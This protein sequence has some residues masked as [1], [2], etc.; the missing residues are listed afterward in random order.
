MS[1]YFLPFDHSTVSMAALIAPMAQIVMAGKGTSIIG[2][3]VVLRVVITRLSCQ[4][5]YIWGQLEVRSA[6]PL[7]R[8][9]KSLSASHPL[10]EYPRQSCQPNADPCP[11]ERGESSILSRRTR[12]VDAVGRCHL[13]VGGRGAPQGTTASHGDYFL[14]H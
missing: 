14:T 2:Y 7:P 1:L 6:T 5:A 12:V 13:G 4:S 9:V 3:P 11:Q 8:L 10:Y